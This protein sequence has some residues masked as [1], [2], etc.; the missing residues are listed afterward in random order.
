MTLIESKP[1]FKGQL[2]SSLTVIAALAASYFVAQ[3]F[4]AL[5]KY[6]GIS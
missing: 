4:V 3:L 2:V 5:E 1:E 6:L